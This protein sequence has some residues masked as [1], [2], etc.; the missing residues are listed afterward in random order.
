MNNIKS[1]LISKFSFFFL[2]LSIAVSAKENQNKSTITISDTFECKLLKKK[3]ICYVSLWKNEDD[4]FISDIIDV[5]LIKYIMKKKL[6]IQKLEFA[7]DTLFQRIYKNISGDENINTI[8]EEVASQIVK[9]GIDY[10]LVVYKY[11]GARKETS[12]FVK[13]M[14]KM[15]QKL[16]KNLSMPAGVGH[17]AN[18]NK[19]NALSCKATFIDV[20]QNK[21][22]IESGL[23]I[24]KSDS[25]GPMV[26]EILKSICEKEEKDN[27]YK[28]CFKI[29]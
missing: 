8:P 4:K 12:E 17:S 22:V 25:I 11:I 2:L 13:V 24:S 3:S 16:G 26:K 27:S 28:P 21:P 10:L 19:F 15:P 29:R 18:V 6:P 14:E 1:N 23:K 5:E 20:A 9:L 7:I